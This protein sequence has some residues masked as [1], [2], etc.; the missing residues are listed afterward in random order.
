M[1]ATVKNF[2]DVFYLFNGNTVHESKLQ[3]DYF[4]FVR[5]NLITCKVT[6]ERMD[7]A[8][9]RSDVFF[10]FAN[11]FIVAE[12]K[13]ETVKMD[14]DG[15]ERKYIGQTMAY[16]G[17]SAKL[18]FLFVLDL[19][20]NDGGIG[21]FETNVKL[22]VSESPEGIKR[23]VVILRMPGNRVTPSNIKQQKKVPK[24]KATKKQVSTRKKNVVSGSVKGN[25]SQKN[26]GQ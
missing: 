1:N 21:A 15:Y 14:M 6:T 4:N 11:F 13:R 12:I 7:V 8:G 5:G 10:E 2:G 26:S 3:N 22:K 23:G 25:K 19:S 17:T 20:N 16:Q 9:G 18:G 24:T